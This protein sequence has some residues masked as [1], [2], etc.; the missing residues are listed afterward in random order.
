MAHR[1]KVGDK[2]IVTGGNYAITQIG[3]YGTVVRIM[4]PG[5]YDV[6][7][8]WYPEEVRRRAYIGHI[9][10]IYED[11]LDFHRPEDISLDPIQR[12][13][14]RLHHQQQFYREHKHDLPSWG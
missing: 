2:V 5:Y 10:D 12:T 8:D 1:F 9:Y 4:R 3:S 13:I 14:K 6:K 7:F 11:Y